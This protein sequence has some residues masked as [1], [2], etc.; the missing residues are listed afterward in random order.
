MN[1][2][3]LN[4]SGRLFAIPSLFEGMARVFD[5]FGLQDI[6]NI[7]SSSQQADAKA[8]YSD[9]A[10]VGDDLLEASHKAF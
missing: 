8:L 3:L 9:W 6:Y 2:S 1:D 10:A 7:D 5:I 4:R